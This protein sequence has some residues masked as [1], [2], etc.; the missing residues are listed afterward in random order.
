MVEIHRFHRRVSFMNVCVCVC[1]VV[2]VTQTALTYNEWNR[3]SLRRASI[4]QMRLQ[5][6]TL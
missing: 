3:I 6:R 2:M 1:V 5:I 4:P